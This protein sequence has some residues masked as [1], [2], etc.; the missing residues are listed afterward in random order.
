MTPAV[1][2]SIGPPEHGVMRLLRQLVADWQPEPVLIELPT[3][4]LAGPSGLPPG[5]TSVGIHFTDQ[6]FGPTCDVAAERFDALVQRLAGIAVMVTLH[7]VPMTSDDPAR[8]ARRAAAYTRVVQAAHTVVVNSEHEATLL[9][10]F[11]P[12]ANPV[13]LPLPLTAPEPGP[14]PTPDPDVAVLGFIYPGKGH[15]PALDALPAGYGLLA[16]G[17]PATGHDD[18]VAELQRHAERVRRRFTV[19]GWIA[20]GELPDRLRRVA[21]PL[22]AHEQLSASASIGTWLAAGRR[23]LVPDSPY[24]RELEDRCPGSVTRYRPAELAA[25]I[26]RTLADPA[27]TWLADDVVL[28]PGTAD[29]AR[30]YRQVLQC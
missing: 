14:R 23:P 30:R 19:S 24:T 7:D 29:V 6:L 5:T 9:R 4:D 21:V 28:G 26:R 18:F 10:S 12:D 11:D 2:L 17:R 20:D 3:P 16:L 22:V 8:Y 13:V 27:G 1:L 25:A 15:L